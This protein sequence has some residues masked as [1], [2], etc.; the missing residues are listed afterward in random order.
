[1]LLECLPG[2]VFTARGHRPVIVGYTEDGQPEYLA[3]ALSKNSRSEN[4]ANIVEEEHI[5]SVS[6][7]VKEGASEV[8]YLVVLEEAKEVRTADHFWVVVLRYDPS[9]DTEDKVRGMGG[10]DVTGQCHWK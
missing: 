6:C 7:T 4:S 10:R 8:N 1:M 3:V 9:D 5:G 2:A